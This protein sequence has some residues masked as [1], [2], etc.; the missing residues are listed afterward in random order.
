MVGGTYTT[1]WREFD[2]IRNVVVSGNTMV[3]A[4]EGQAHSLLV[5]SP[6]IAA[7]IANN[8][9]IGGDFGIVSKAD[10]CI[11]KNNIVRSVVTANSYAG[12]GRNVAINNTFIS[13]SSGATV[14]VGSTAPLGADET[15]L[16][17]NIMMNTSTGVCLSIHT[18]TGKVYCDFNC[19]F[20]SGSGPLAN[21]KGTVCNTIAE[22]QAAWIAD[23]QPNND[24]NSI[25]VDPLF[26]DIVN[27]DYRLLPNS[28]CL[29]TGQATAQDG[30]VSFGAWQRKSILR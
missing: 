7:Y 12:G 17:N 19:Y 23:G 5:G 20:N 24:V 18:S 16:V 27:D 3:D 6:V 14:L 29:N 30:L 10:G 25:E 15:K 28:P 1:N 11:I 22:I 9:F 26:A 21:I 2:F 8:K 13:G 4:T